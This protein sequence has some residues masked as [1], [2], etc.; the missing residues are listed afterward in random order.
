MELDHDSGGGTIVLCIGDKFLELIEIVVEGPSALE[1]PRAFQFV[2]C[3]SLC[4]SRE[5]FSAEDFFKVCPT[6]ESGSSGW[7]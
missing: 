5:E 4:I 7:S 1:V 3:C 2:Y 6:I